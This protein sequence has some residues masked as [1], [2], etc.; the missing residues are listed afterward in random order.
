MLGAVICGVCLICATIVICKTGRLERENDF[1]AGCYGFSV[2]HGFILICKPDFPA[3]LT[4]AVIIGFFVVCLW[5]VVLLGLK[6]PD[7]PQYG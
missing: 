3:D 4:G 7:C 2:N 5:L 1:V 6:K